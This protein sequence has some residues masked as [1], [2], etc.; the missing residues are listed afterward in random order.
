MASDL[1]A[2]RL[3]KKVWWEGTGLR[4]ERIGLRW[5]V[6]PK[7]KIGVRGHPED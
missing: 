4:W 1:E 6:G 2:C 7:E 5:A 3:L